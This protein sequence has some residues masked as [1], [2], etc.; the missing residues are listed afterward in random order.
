MFKLSEDTILT[1][2]HI[3]SYIDNHRQE[4]A[5]LEK[6]YKYYKG[7]HDIL[8]RVMSD[9]NKPNNKMVNP[10]ANYITDMMTGYFMGK[11][12]TYTSDDEELVEVVN[13]TYNQNDEQAHNAILAK[14]GSIF[15]V[16]Y[17]LVYVD[18][19][20]NTRFL[21]LDSREV[22]PIYNDTLT[23][24][25]LYVIRYYSVEDVLTKDAITKIEVYSKDEVNYYTWGNN[26]LIQTASQPHVFGAVPVNE[27]LNNDERLGDYETVTSLID[28]YDK[29]ESDSINDFDLFADAYLTLTGVELP[30]DDDGNPVTPDFRNSRLIVL[31][32][33]DAKADWLIKDTPD[34]HI[35]NMKNRI[36][37]DIHTFSK[38]PKLT[39]ENFAGNASGV[40]MQYKLM[41][42]EN[43]TAKKERAFKKG[44]QRRLKLITA[45]LNIKGNA[46]DYRNID[47]TFTRNLPEDLQDK[48]DLINKLQGLLSKETLIAQIPFITDVQ[49]E[50]DRIEEE[51]KNTIQPFNIMPRQPLQDDINDGRQN[52]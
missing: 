42:L 35:E 10:Y 39:D 2:Q 27:Y 29:L 45:I 43:A 1:A 32:A 30:T 23:N 20:A 31:P 44:L 16:A 19:E 28:A 41:G 9:A 47:I 34:T 11:P 13:D 38:C 5:R 51:D 48:A 50:L 40:A 36:E 46:F 18:E 24:D 8:N 17:E 52:Q 37:K 26:G 7:Q 14:N 33:S 15:G 4:K 6:L 21:P 25:L 12:V 22:I 49:G 3:T